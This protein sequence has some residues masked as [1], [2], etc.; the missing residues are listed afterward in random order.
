MTNTT[1]TSAASGVADNCTTLPDGSAFAV[2]SFPLPQDHWLYAPHE[3]EPG[4]DEPKELLAPILTHAQRNEVV[5]AVRY[6]VRGAT[7]CGKEPDFDP[8]A[9]VQNAV[10]ALCGSFGRTA[11]ATTAQADSQPALPEITADCHPNLIAAELRRLHAENETLTLYKSLADEYGLSIFKDLKDLGDAGSDVQLLRMGYAAARLEIQS[12]QARI[13]TM[14]E[15][16]A[17]ELMVAHL[18]GRAQAAQPAP[19]YVGKGMF[20]GETIE[21]A[22][23]HWANWCDCRYLEGL[24]EFLRVVAARASAESVLED[25]A[26]PDTDAAFEAVRR[27]LCKIPRYSFALDSRGNVRRCEDKSGN[28]IEFDAAHALFDPVAVDAAR[29]QGANHD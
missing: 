11:L 27:G 22:A 18:D 1:N 3:Y 14:A 23:E 25:A 15:E 13:K 26:R 16:H 8:D 10:Y 7:M 6:A 29:K 2:G 12:L 28:W 21:K 20:K 9:L 19:E 5:A 4:A 24:A 17:D